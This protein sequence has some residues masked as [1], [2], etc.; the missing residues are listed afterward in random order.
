MSWVLTVYFAGEELEELGLVGHCE[1]PVGGLVDYVVSCA[2]VDEVQ[3][4]GLCVVFELKQSISILI[5]L[6]L[7]A[8]VRNGLEG[9]LYS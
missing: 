3:L 6:L 1:N 4:V 2:L 7:G 8:R 9:E 5:S